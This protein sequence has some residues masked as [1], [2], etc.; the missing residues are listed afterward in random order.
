MFGGNL[1]KGQDADFADFDNA[2][3]LVAAVQNQ[4]EAAG[5]RQGFLIDGV[6]VVGGRGGGFFAAQNQIGQVVGFDAERPGVWLFA[7]FGIDFPA[8]V[9][10]LLRIHKCSL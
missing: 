9:P 4:M 8:F 5:L 7:E 3:C 2:D 6:K 1:A 10:H